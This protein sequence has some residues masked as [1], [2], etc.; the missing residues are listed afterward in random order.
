MVRPASVEIWKQGVRAEIRKAIPLKKLAGFFAQHKEEL[1]P[2]RI[3]RAKTWGRFD[4]QHQL[5]FVDDGLLPIVE[6]EIGAR[7]SGLVEK[8]VGQMRRQLSHR[9]MTD[10]FGHWLLKSTFWL[11]AAKILGDK[12][13]DTFAKLDFTR[14]DKLFPAVRQHYGSAEDLS[15]GGRAE[16]KALSAAAETIER[17]S[18]LGHMTTE[19]L[20]YVYENTLI[21]KQTRTALGTHSTPSYLVDY[22]VWRLA[23]WIKELPE[24]DRHVFEPACGHAAF[25]VSAMRLLREMLPSS[26]A[27]AYRKRYLRKRLH[28]VEIDSFALE[29]ARLSLTLADVP[30]PNGWQLKSEDMFQ[31]KLLEDGA[32][33]ANI[34][35]A[36]PPF[37]DFTVREKRSYARRGIQVNHINK[38]AE[39]LGRTLPQLKHGAVFGVVVPQGFLHSKNSADVRKTLSQDFEIQEIC[40][41]PDKVFAF[42]DNETAIILGRRRQ[43]AREAITT[44]RYC[45]VREGG[46]DKF[47]DFYKPTSESSVAS[48]WFAR[49]TQFDLRLPDFHDI[50]QWLVKRSSLDQYAELGQ[51]LAYHG[52][53]LPKGSVTISDKRRKGLSKGFARFTSNI[54]LHT[55]PPSVWLNLDEKVVQHRRT[56]TDTGIPQVLINYAPV[57]RGPWRIKAMIDGDG[58]AVT[59]RFITVRPRESAI[60]LEFLWAVLN[61]PV[62]N[63]FAYS[64]L[65]KRDILVG[66]MRRLPVP[67]ISTSGIGSVNEVV[68]RYLELVT[69]SGFLQ[70]EAD[71]KLVRERLLDIDAEIL[72]LYDLPPSMERR[73]LELFAGAKRPGVPAVFDRYYPEGFDPFIPLHIY[74]SAAFQRSTVDRLLKQRPKNVPEALVSALASASEAFAEE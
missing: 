44:V 66:T 23:P 35:L 65:M 58:H 57:S 50:W 32:S 68:R 9:R 34:L 1:A 42:A 31:G 13:V 63:A 30:N 4:Q 46:L 49:D 14:V 67:Q 74:R 59:S 55:L 40:L 60:S 43:T 37:E 18:H 48:S 54:Q 22:M 20:A 2:E 39:M 28:G 33:Q 53:R 73:I 16:R 8:V 29:I 61:S 71:H 3:Y 38:T 62:A 69:P 36:N 15:I 72:R 19:S 45:R 52:K 26:K 10:A 41:F 25:L 5:A 27:P 56:G 21:S 7:L 70:P 12:G 24:S 64:H 17:F 51:G 11:L 6:Q 47:R